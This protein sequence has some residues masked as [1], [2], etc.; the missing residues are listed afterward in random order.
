MDRMR[1]GRYPS[2]VSAK[3]RNLRTLD[4]CGNDIALDFINTVHSRVDPEPHEYL[5]TYADLVTWAH[6]GGIVSGDWK[7]PHAGHNDS[8][9]ASRVLRRAIELRE[10]LYRLFSA[11][12]HGTEP[13][14][15]DVNALNDWVREA[16]TH[17]RLGRTATGYEWRWDA[18]P[19]AL[20]R[21]L[22]PIVLSAASLLAS[23]KHDRIRECPSPDGC[24]WLFLDISKNGRRR[25]CNMRTC[26]NVSKARRHYRRTK[27]H[28]V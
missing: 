8:Q 28:A 20:E 23:A 14:A 11:V 16:H 7:P 22:W 15:H 17:R 10:V 2:P 18:I 6:D 26:G 25:W 19:D 1:P 3:K 5:R 24:G 9:H 12:I 4:R 21:P 13:V 27:K